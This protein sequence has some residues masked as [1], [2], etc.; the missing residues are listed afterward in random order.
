MNHE[1][2]NEMNNHDERQQPEDR[3]PPK[4]AADASGRSWLEALQAARMGT[5]RKR[6]AHAQL[7]EAWDLHE[8]D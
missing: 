5:E 8:D 3:E 4:Y 7:R 6:E 1:E 2:E